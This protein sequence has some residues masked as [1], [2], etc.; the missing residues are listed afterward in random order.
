ML[1]Q[2]N[3]EMKIKMT[4][5]MT[6]VVVKEKK[7]RLKDHK[8]KRKKVPVE[9]EDFQKFYRAENFQLGKYFLDT[10]IMMT[11]WEFLFRGFMTVGL[12]DDLNEG[13]I[14]FQMV[15]FTLLHIGKPLVECIACIPAGLF[16]GYVCYK[17]ESFWLALIMHMAVHM[18]LICGSVGYF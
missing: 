13:S 17:S 5:M 7:R 18:T 2:K 14:L 15:P 4:M 8:R 12:E 6:T 3:R 10:L 11:G 1:K 16:W 9:N